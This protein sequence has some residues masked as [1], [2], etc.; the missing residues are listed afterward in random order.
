MLDFIP[1][2][3]R[4][5]RQSVW[6]TTLVI[7]VYTATAVS[8]GVAFGYA[9]TILMIALLSWQNIVFDWNGLF[10]LTSLFGIG[11]VAAGLLVATVVE[12]RRLQEHGGW[13][14][15][16]ALGG[17]HIDT[18]QC[19]EERRLLNIVEE[20][21]IV[22]RTTPPAVLVLDNEPGIN[23]LAA[24]LTPQDSIIVVT[25]GAM[26][27]LNREQLQGVIAHEYS[28]LV[29]GDTRL[30]T[31][32]SSILWAL[33][34]VHSLSR[35]IILWGFEEVECRSAAF[36][37][38]YLLIFVGMIV[39]PF[40]LIGTLGAALLSLAICRS[41]EEL[42]DAEAVSHARNPQGLADAM[43]RVMGHPHHG[44]LRHLRCPTIAPMLFVSPSRHEHWYSTHPPLLR[45]IAAIDPAGGLQPIERDSPV[46]I[47]LTNK[48]TKT[49]KVL[50]T[51]FPENL[52]TVGLPGLTNID[53][54]TSPVDVFDNLL[55]QPETWAMTVP[56]LMG[57]KPS[58]SD[59][60][61]TKI[62][63]ALCDGDPRQR[64]AL[65][66]QAIESAKGFHPSTRSDVVDQVSRWREQTDNS[67]WLACGSLW[68]LQKSLLGNYPIVDEVPRASD[69]SA[70]DAARVIMSVFSGCDEDNPMAD[71]EFARGWSELRYR[72]AV[73]VPI[74]L[75]EWQHFETS[76]EIF[77]TVEKRERHDLFLA[78]AHVVSADSR[79]DLT[80]AVLCHVLK[81]ALDLP[82]SIMLPDE[83]AVPIV[84]STS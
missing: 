80:E 84:P 12:R 44:R 76:V 63:E 82:S 61:K 16:L 69:E 56:L 60:V 74:K 14:I 28:H 19:Q 1:R 48:S 10:A 52:S 57:W 59:P 81:V 41:R 78:C 30:G 27:Q 72:E 51:L 46:V 24:G 29:N 71:Y 77:S 67:D 37:Y 5:Y 65:L 17:R 18:P 31:R 4:S 38:G 3:I 73:R 39:W 8:S 22:Y 50:R 58:D 47:T 7:V 34:G 33:D 53:F 43:R 83:V 35:W 70:S 25:A 42:A 20:L 32:L 11:I 68:L 54:L 40:G 64:F 66:I 23:A 49:A 21:A 15:G 9:I 13:A 75:L 6:L 26:M 79:I 55:D 45:R 2:K 62:Q 36:L